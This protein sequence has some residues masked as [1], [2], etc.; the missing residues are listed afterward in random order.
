MGILKFIKKLFAPPNVEENGY[1]ETMRRLGA[2]E[3]TI[4]RDREYRIM[5]QETT[6][7]KKV[8]SVERGAIL[9]SQSLLMKASEKADISTMASLIKSGSSI[10]ERDYFGNTA[11]FYAL[12]SSNKSALKLLLESG[13]NINS[14]SYPG[15]ATVLINAAADDRFGNIDIIELLLNYGA[16]INCKDVDGYTALAYASRKNRA[17]IVQLLIN[18][19]ANVNVSDNDNYTPLMRAVQEDHVSTVKILIKHNADINFRSNEGYTAKDIAKFRNI[20]EIK[21][22]LDE[23][24]GRN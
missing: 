7:P 3:T 10:D 23:V 17:D 1:S 19:G 9:E 14:K 18:H 4:K 2:S 21:K 15:K 13:A 24:T 11:L 8:I 6:I 12:R 20:F 22:L 5:M 16:D